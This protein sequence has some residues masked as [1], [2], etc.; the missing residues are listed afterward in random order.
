[1]KTLKPLSVSLAGKSAKATKT[2]FFVIIAERCMMASFLWV[3]PTAETT[4]WFF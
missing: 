4:R 2:L 1:M 3:A